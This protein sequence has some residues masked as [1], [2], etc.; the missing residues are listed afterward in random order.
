MG[1]SLTSGKSETL[2][3]FK[4]NEKSI[5][6]ILDIGAGSGTYINLIK[7][8]NAVCVN[9]DWVGIEAWQNYI[10]EFQLTEKYNTIINQDARTLDWQQLGKFSVAIAGDVLEHMTKQEAIALVKSILDN[11]DTL[12]ISIPIIHMPQDEVNG[13][14]FEVHVKDDWSHEEVMQTWS[15]FIKDSYRKGKKS[16]I[17]VYW[18]SK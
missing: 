10:D 18:L 11:C 13:N 16:K 2:Q 1:T 6:R 7:F 14:P 9:A 17:G 12:I 8:N 5:N 3:W 4:D 15:M